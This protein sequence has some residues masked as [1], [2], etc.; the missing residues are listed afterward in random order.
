[1]S[2]A[3]KKRIENVSIVSSKNQNKELEKSNNE[4]DDRNKAEAMFSETLA[5]TLLQNGQGDV[6]DEE[7]EAIIDLDQKLM[8]KG[9]RILMIWIITLS[10]LM[11]SFMMIMMTM[12]WSL[13]LKMN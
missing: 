11:P 5:M 3:T 4:E 12:A 9:T 13:N 10:I 1:M 7:L 6:S 8:L 2:V